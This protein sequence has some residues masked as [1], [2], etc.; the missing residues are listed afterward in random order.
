MFASVYV[1]SGVLICTTVQLR[2]VWPALSQS[3]GSNF[4]SRII[5][6]ILVDAICFY[7]IKKIIKQKKKR[8]TLSHRFGQTRLSGIVLI[9]Y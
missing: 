7:F 4:L 1:S 5:N 8:R 2:T 3:E 6:R 9:L